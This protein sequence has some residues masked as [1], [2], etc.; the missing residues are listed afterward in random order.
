MKAKVMRQ[1]KATREKY[2][3][4]RL[5]KAMSE[6]LRFKQMQKANGIFP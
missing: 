1:E 5:E 6:D 4:K 2:E 3:G